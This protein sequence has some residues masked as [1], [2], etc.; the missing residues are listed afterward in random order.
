[1]KNAIRS[2]NV[3]KDDD[4][5]ITL[6]KVIFGPHYFLRIEFNEEQKI[7]FTVGATHHGVKFK[8]NEVNDELENV[9]EFLRK[10]YPNNVID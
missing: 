4:G 1:M 5:K 8:A 7:T 3:K 10:N 9:I 6:I 2:V